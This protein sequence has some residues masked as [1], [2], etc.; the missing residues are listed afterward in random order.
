MKQFFFVLVM[1]FITVS[2]FPQSSSVTTHANSALLDNERWNLE[3]YLWSYTKSK[4]QSNNKLLIDF[5]V[6]DNWQGLG[7]YLSITDDGR[8][9]AYTIERGIWVRDYYKKMD[10]LIIQ[11]ITG[12]WRRSFAGMKPG[13]FTMDNKQ[14]VLHDKNVLY[15]LQVGTEKDTVINNV[16]TYVTTGSKNKWI[17]YQ[18]KKEGKPV[19]LQNLLTGKIKEFSDVAS[20]SFD[21]SKQW[22]LCRL[23]T[24]LNELLTFNL[25]SGKEQNYS[26]TKSY[27]FS[28]DG[29]ALLFYTGIDLQYV[30]FTDYTTNTIWSTK[31][32]SKVLSTYKFDNSGSQV[33]F[34]IRDLSNTIESTSIWY[35]RK[36]LNRAVLKV[37][38]E[39]SGIGS[40]FQIQGAATFTDNGHYIQ[41]VL[42]R[43]PEIRQPVS[44][45]V[46]ID[47]WG[48]RDLNLYSAQPFLLKRPQ[49]YNAIIG[50]ENDHV[51]QLESEGKTM[52]LLHGDFAIVKKSDKEMHGDRFWER[53]Y[54]GN[55]DSNWLVSISNGSRRLLPIKGGNGTFWFSPGGSYLVYFNSDKG[56][57]Y[58][59]F[60]LQTGA[61]KDVSANVPEGQL[62]LVDPLLRSNKKPEFPLNLAAWLQNDSGLLVYDNNDI[63]QLDLT[64]KKAAVNITNGFGRTHGIMFSLMN[65]ERHL[66]VTPTLN[67]EQPLLLRAF[68]VKNKYSGFYSKVIG[69]VGDPKLIYM[70][71]YFMNMIMWGQDPNLSNRGIQPL[72]ARD[73][74]TWIVQRQSTTDAPNYYK[75]ADLKSYE[76]LTNFQPQN[77]YRWF[78][79]EL[80]TFKHL[81][82]T[83]GQ[84]ILYKPENFD[85]SKKY[86]VLIVFYG[87]YSN[88]LYQF[89]APV[90]NIN[91]ITPG[92]SPIWLLNNG[93]LIFTPDIHVAP[94]KYGPEAFNIIEGAVRYL[95]R[96]PFID[97]NKLGC[98]AHSW[99]AKLGAYLFTHSK[100]FGAVAI[101]EGFLYANMINTAL[102]TDQDGISKLKT[103][104]MDF[105]FGKFWKNKESWLDQTT[106]V[107]VDK[108]NSPLL[109]LCNKRSAQE[110]QNQT[111]Q[112]FTSLRRLEKKVWW[113]KY[114]KGGHNLND[115]DEMKDYTIRYT[116]YFDHYLKEAPAPQWMSKGIPYKLKGV[117]SRYE[118]DPQ[119]ACTSTNGKPCTICEAWNEQY[120]RTPEMFQK[121]IKDW[122]LDKDIADELVRKI[123]ERRKVLDKEAEIQTKEVMRMLNK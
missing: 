77:E 37:N 90:Y 7:D 74:D 60:N 94:L 32:T 44:N 100:S 65:S 21:D 56:C 121:E 122:V 107:N 12:S 84:G 86:P 69:A 22:F 63:W 4:S 51:I 93:Y 14:Y 91:A 108:A 6:I 30:S 88:N 29:N 2:T 42:E 99:S 70:G 95:K 26:S 9:F 23:N 89:H 46:Q 106:V 75:T 97:K 28:P 114:E 61:L 67:L 111:L 17:A 19:I 73:V 92:V 52:S 10:S 35:Y 71:Q 18:L 81:N 103:V 66:Y 15:F 62:G 33:V 45:A 113:L 54:G 40:G 8:Y 41:F 43:K 83:T 110:Y 58:F 48:Y 34:A 120:K 47:V 1:V 24:S 82:G 53:G 57:H 25:E 104:E 64:G 55:E 118:L 27:L 109:L 49:I 123:N 116:Q 96:L 16:E 117:E 101:S 119:G 38:K 36:D 72:K 31:D 105:K 85:S 79:E 78:S 112:L 59:S 102:S 39:T 115:L 76:R 98:S 80:H 87:Q 50:I 3:K 20:Y 5:N 13:F 11:S 68:N